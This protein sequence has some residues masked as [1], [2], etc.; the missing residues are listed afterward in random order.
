MEFFFFLFFYWRLRLLLLFC[1]DLRCVVF[2]CLFGVV[3]VFLWLFCE[4]WTGYCV[5]RAC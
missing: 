1:F 4:N 5:L 3:A 2:G